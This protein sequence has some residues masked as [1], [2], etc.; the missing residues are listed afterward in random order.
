MLVSLDHTFSLVVYAN[1]V[2]GLLL[3]RVSVS[4]GDDPQIYLQIQIARFAM[5][6]ASLF[7]YLINAYFSFYGS[8]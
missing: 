5:I 2:S 1:V 8:N 4:W 3:D 7:A 6:Q